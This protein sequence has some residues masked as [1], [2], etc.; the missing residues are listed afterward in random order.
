M[1]PISP[2]DHALDGLELLRRLSLCDESGLHWIQ[3]E[4]EWTDKQTP[5]PATVM[6]FQFGEFKQCFMRLLSFLTNHPPDEEADA[7]DP[8]MYDPGLFSPPNSQPSS[9][10]RAEFAQ[11]GDRDKVSFA[12]PSPC[13]TRFHASSGRPRCCEVICPSCSVMATACNTE[14]ASPSSSAIPAF[15][16]RSGSRGLSVHAALAVSGNQCARSAGY[17]VI[18]MQSRFGRC[19][20]IPLDKLSGTAP[21][22]S[23]WVEAFCPAAR[24]RAQVQEILA[25]AIASPG[26]TPRDRGLLPFDVLVADENRV[27]LFSV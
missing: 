1:R 19:L 24:W 18:A 12:F 3:T 26:I 8:S 7:C 13:S 10:Q 21:R 20:V 16:F 15:T 4:A 17:S 2:C 22:P 6:P 9:P 5:E 23:R 25:K 27:A 11:S 14:V